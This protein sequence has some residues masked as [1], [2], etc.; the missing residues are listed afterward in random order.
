MTISVDSRTLDLPFVFERFDENTWKD[1][2][3]PKLLITK[4][5]IYEIQC[6]ICKDRQNIPTYEIFHCTTTKNIY[7]CG[8]ALEW[9][10]RHNC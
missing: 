8:L 5:N 1:K 10:V 4:T 6:R 3:W 9:A 7:L 2:G